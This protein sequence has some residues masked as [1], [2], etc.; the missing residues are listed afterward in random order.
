VPALMA[1]FAQWNWCC[2][3][4][5]PRPA[6]GGLRRRCPD[7]DL[8][9]VVVIPDDITRRCCPQ[10]GRADG[11]QVGGELKRLAPTPFA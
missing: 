4:A 11:D 5:A 6:V 9:D 2:P 7:V 8:A 1:M 3:M 10:R